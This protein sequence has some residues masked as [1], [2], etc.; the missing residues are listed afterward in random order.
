MKYRITEIII[1]LFLPVIMILIGINR[2]ILTH[3][4][5]RQSCKCR[6]RVLDR[7]ARAF[8]PSLH[9]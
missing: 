1:Y 8:W 9:V 2:R 3:R 6:L 4:N 5:T 7:N